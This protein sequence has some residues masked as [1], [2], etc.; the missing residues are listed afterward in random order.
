M[1]PWKNIGEFPSL[2]PRG[3]LKKPD[4]PPS[5]RQKDTTNRPHCINA[6]F[7]K[8]RTTRQEKEKE[9]NL[10][11]PK[12]SEGNSINDKD[13]TIGEVEVQILPTPFFF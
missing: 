10:S 2:G 1:T 3:E 9:V 4:P 11:C 8:D 13:P 5:R 6:R 7:S 12:P